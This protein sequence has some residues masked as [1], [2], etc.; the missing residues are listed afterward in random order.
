MKQKLISIVLL[1]AFGA[2]LLEPAA[3]FVQYFIYQYKQNITQNDNCDCQC[4]QEDNEVAPMENNG[5]NYLKA[6]IKRACEDQKKS[7][8]PAI[9]VLQVSVYILNL[10]NDYP[11][12]F[13]CPKENFN[14][15][16]TFIIQPD[17]QSYITDI[18]HPPASV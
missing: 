8:K 11:K 15:I 18:F 3:P 2:I 10:T 14:K 1:L 7:K 17:L 9:P 16:S 13:T 6:L 12:V 4:A 5:N